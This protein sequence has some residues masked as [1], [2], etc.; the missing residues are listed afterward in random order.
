MASEL[1]SDVQDTVE[2]GRKWLVDFNAGKTQLVWFDQ[3]NSTG[4]IDV[5]RDGSVLEEKSFFKMLGLTLSSKLDWGSYIIFIAETASKK[6]G[7]LIHF[8]KFLFPEV[9]LY[10]YKSTIWPCMEYC[11]HVWGNAPIC[12]LELLDKVDVY[13][14]WLNWL[15]LLILED[16]PWELVSAA[17]STSSAS[18][19]Y[20]DKLHDFSIIIPRSYIDVYVNSFFPRTSRLWN[21]LPIEYFF[22]PLRL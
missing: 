4:A 11:C 15:H 19:H 17:S 20:S 16:L 9:A 18:T 13:L 8:S 10:L 2:L 6:I 22:L 1:E 5:K 21:S 12:Y 7:A 3:S 14:N